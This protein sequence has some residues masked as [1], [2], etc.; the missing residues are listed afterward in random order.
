MN[1]SELKD[2]LKDKRVIEAINKHLWIESQKAGYSIGI[3]SATEE[4][5]R[6]YALEWMKY[7]MADRY[8]QFTKKSKKRK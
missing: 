4:W 7:N 3:E 5:L 6:L 8:A 1:I 2:L